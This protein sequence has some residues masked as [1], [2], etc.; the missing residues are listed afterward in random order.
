METYAQRSIRHCIEMIAP[1]EMPEQQ[2]EGG[3]FKNA[4]APIPTVDDI[5]K[6][7]SVENAA[8]VKRLE[9]SLSG[10]KCKT[11]NQ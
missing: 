3:Q 6:T 2:E 7:L 8:I 5:C 10:I 4:C 1:F 11:K 9:E